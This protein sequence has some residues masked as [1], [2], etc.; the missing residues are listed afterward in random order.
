MLSSTVGQT[1]RTIPPD[2][3]IQDSRP[4]SR[5]GFFAKAHDFSIESLN[6]YNQLEDEE[7]IRAKMYEEW[8]K[9]E[10]IEWEM[11]GEEAL[12]RLGGAARPD[13]MLDRIESAGYVPS[14]DEG[15]RESLRDR[16]TYWGRKIE[17]VEQCLLWLFG[18]A[19]VGKS[20]VA[21]SVAETLR[22]E[23]YF[24]AVFF[25]SRPNNRSDPDA[26]RTRPTIQSKS[27]D[28][29]HKSPLDAQR[30]LVEL[31]GGY[32]CLDYHHRLR[33][34]ICSR[35]DP[36]IAAAFDALEDK[37]IYCQ[38]EIEVDT[39]EA[40]KDAFCILD[41]GFIA[42]RRRFP[43]QLD[44]SW[45][46]QSHF[47]EHARQSG[48]RNPLH[49]LDLLYT[50]IFSDIPV[51]TLPNTKLVLG[52]LILL[53]NEQF[54]AHLLASFPGLSQAAFYSSLHH[55]H[56]VLLI[57]MHD[58]AHETN[59]RVYHASFSDFLRDKAR[60]GQ[61]FLDEEAVQLHIATR[62]LKWLS[63]FGHYPHDQVSLPEPRWVSQLAPRETVINTLSKV[64]FAPTWRAFPR[65]SE[66]DLAILEEEIR[67][68]DFSL[69][70][71]EHLRWYSEDDMEAFGHFL[72]WL[73]SSKLSSL[74]RLDRRRPGKAG[75][76]DEI[77]VVWN[78]EDTT[79]FIGPLIQNV[80]PTD[81]VSSLHVEIRARSRAVFHLVFSTSPRHAGQ[82]S[83]NDIVIMLVGH[84]N[85]G[86]SLFIEL[87][88]QQAVQH[89]SDRVGPGASETKAVRVLHPKYGNRIVL[90]DTP[91]LFVNT[92]SIDKWFREK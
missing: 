84:D 7:K 55:M 66:K 8:R 1:Q 79:A 80:D 32:V 19:G 40:R 38:E 30:E 23:E 14:C 35:P 82:F 31:I 74:A 49:A 17:M 24:G 54:T 75:K 73:L 45:P 25:F 53:K 78:E 89:A 16:L 11:R 41:K 39:P 42:I 36:E 2:F 56:S 69:I 68:F 72:R 15:T 60:S 57:P 10:T 52:I 33:W 71:R 67:N 47:L 65:V 12:Q 28:P 44:H 34:M 21:Q 59:I 85:D 29:K 27:P 50:R 9:M 83:E 46:D 90:V 61:Y 26:A 3:A 4:E 51:D 58:R 87:L 18:P 6:V 70:G 91:S 88:T 13:A 48:N 5:N 86:K 62:G 20:A 37:I 92:C 22:R 76:K 63:H 43:R 81:H 77:T 64:A